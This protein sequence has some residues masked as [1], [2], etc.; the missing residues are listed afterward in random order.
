[1][2]TNATTSALFDTPPNPT[3]TWSSERKSSK[4][5]PSRFF[6]ASHD[7]FSSLINCSSIAALSLDSAVTPTLEKKTKGRNK[8]R[9]SVRLMKAP[10]RKR[11]E[12][13]GHKTDRIG[14]RERNLIVVLAQTLQ[15]LS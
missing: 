2:P 7:C 14:S 9:R 15:V 8:R 5:L 1:M 4:N 12:A 11:R 10:C 13:Q 3:S 6:Q